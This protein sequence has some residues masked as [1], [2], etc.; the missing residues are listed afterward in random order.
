MRHGNKMADIGRPSSSTNGALNAATSKLID[1]W[2][3]FSLRSTSDE[4]AADASGEGLPLSHGI[5]R[6]AQTESSG[7]A[8]PAG[9][10]MAGPQPGVGTAACSSAKCTSYTC[11]VR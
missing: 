10:T 9:T 11:H 2:L 6:Q 1:C 7:K 5:D 8:R 3:A 4:R